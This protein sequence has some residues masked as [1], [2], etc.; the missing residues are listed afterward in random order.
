MISE[1]FHQYIRCA[2]ANDGK[3][4]ARVLA[5]LECLQPV[6]C[7]HSEPRIHVLACL[8]ES[9]VASGGGKML[10]R[11]VDILNQHGFTASAVHALPCFRYRWFE[12]KTR[13][14]FL[15]PGMVRTSD[16]LVIPE[17]FGP[18]MGEIGKGVRKIIYN[19]GAYNT[20]NGY[21]LDS[22][23]RITPYEHEEIDAVLVVSED[24]RNYLAHTF[25][26]LRL[27]RIFYSVDPKVFHFEPQKKKQICFMPRKRFGEIVQVINILKF[28][29][30]LRDYELVPVENRSEKEVAALMR[31]SLIYLSTSRTEG[32]GL[33]AAEAMA[34]G[35]IVVGYTGN[36]GQEFLLP[37]YAFPVPDSD[38]V[39][40][41]KA[42]ENVITAFDRDP[43]AVLDRGRRAS[44]FIHRTYTPAAEAGS[45]VR[46]WETIMELKPAMDCG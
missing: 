22:K 12:N 8:H 44:E 13:V 20:F 46:A 31:E 23:S 33:P 3:A 35:C 27:F 10:Y 38:I 32:F 29:G 15:Q 17:V 9:Q 30:V 39:G 42:V 14:S 1:A 6:P 36:G 37:E 28:R 43:S 25:N 18:F 19:Q 24:S 45:I 4:I 21:Q 5:V 40:F 26:K 2:C 34:C 11:H 7:G 41:A 16:I